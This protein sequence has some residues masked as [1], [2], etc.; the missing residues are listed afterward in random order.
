[1]AKGYLEREEQGMGNENGN[2][3]MAME[4][5]NKEWE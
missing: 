5:E 1:M 2:C 3:G 4:S